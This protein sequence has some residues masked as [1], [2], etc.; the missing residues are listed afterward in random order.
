[1]YRTILGDFTRTLKSVPTRKVQM[2]D[3]EGYCEYCTVPAGGRSL[4]EHLDNGR[5]VDPNRRRTEDEIPLRRRSS[6]STSVK[7]P[8]ELD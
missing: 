5:E 7:I 6:K 4:Q 1:M 2:T 8:R 3:Q